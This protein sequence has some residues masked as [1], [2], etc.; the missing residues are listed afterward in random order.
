M[1]KHKQ[2]HYETISRHLIMPSD[3]NPN[4]SI[5]GGMLIAWLDKDLYIYVSSHVKCRQM[6][7]VSMDKVYFKN[8]AYLGE[9]IEISGAVKQVRR[10][11]VTALGRA[12]AVDPENGQSRIIIE[13]EISYVAIDEHGRPRLLSR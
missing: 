9:V 11:S 8:P 6:V 13:C 4:H 1:E 3:L 7:T 2:T 5:F 12:V 10:T